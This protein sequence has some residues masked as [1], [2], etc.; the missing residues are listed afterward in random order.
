[1][2]KLLCFLLITQGLYINIYS[3][4]EF[5]K[6]KYFKFKR[7]HWSVKLNEP[8]KLKP[9][10][11]RIEQQTNCSY[12]ITTAKPIKDN[13]LTI[14]PKKPASNVIRQPT[15]TQPEKIKLTSVKNKIEKTKTQINIANKIVSQPKI[16]TKPPEKKE[17]KEMSKAFKIIIT[18]LFYTALGVGLYLLSQV[19]PLGMI[20]AIVIVAL[21]LLFFLFLA[22]LSKQFS[23]RLT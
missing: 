5:S 23:K 3:D 20:I 22:F 19:S 8:V 14:T 6:R 12:Q 18:I 17:K 11:K 10:I 16:Q 15:N 13:D 1:M 7:N 9:N 4:T 2:K 21:I